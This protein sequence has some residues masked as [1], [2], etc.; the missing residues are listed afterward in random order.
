MLAQWSGKSGVVVSSQLMP[1]MG[2]TTN[3]HATVDEQPSEA[4]ELAVCTKNFA[5]PLPFTSVAPYVVD[6]GLS[7]SVEFADSG[8]RPAH[9]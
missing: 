7:A 2:M 6:P 3:R 1:M 5:A 8:G 4:F 9:P